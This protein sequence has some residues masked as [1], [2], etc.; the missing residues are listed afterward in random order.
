MAKDEKK[1]EI[2][3]PDVALFWDAKMP[4]TDWLKEAGW[5]T[6]HPVSYQKRMVNEKP[7]FEFVFMT[8]KKLKVRGT[9]WLTEKAIPFYINLL[10]LLGVTYKE[11]EKLGTAN[12]AD[13]AV[14]REKDVVF[15]VQKDASGYCR[16]D[17][18]QILS[19]DDDNIPF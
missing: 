5:N 4:D 13:F 2:G 9:F 7:V 14:A 10:K 12:T 18:T 11:A 1:P 19:T 15:F 8:E 16:V 17:T 6:G 3:I